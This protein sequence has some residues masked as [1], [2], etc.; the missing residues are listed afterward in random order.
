MT[1]KL[2]TEQ[3]SLVAALEEFESRYR[4]MRAE[5]SEFV[6]TAKEPPCW[7]GSPVVTTENALSKM[8]H[9]VDVLQQPIDDLKVELGRK[10]SFRGQ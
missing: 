1:N 4:R 2:K 5:L 3:D 6:D 9:W 10:V 7:D 8:Q